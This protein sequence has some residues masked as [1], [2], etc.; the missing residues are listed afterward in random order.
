MAWR[1]AHPIDRAGDI[2]GTV[3]AWAVFLMIMAMPFMR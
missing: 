2:I 3:I 1:S